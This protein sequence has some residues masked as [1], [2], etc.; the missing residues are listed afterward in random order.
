M[1]ESLLCLILGHLH[2]DLRHSLVLLIKSTV[3]HIEAKE[4]EEKGQEL[5]PLE[6]AD[7]GFECFSLDSEFV[8]TFIPDLLLLT[9]AQ[10]T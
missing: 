3:D 5:I 7:F 9:A 6:A 4:T 1:V 8:P 2:H 10:V